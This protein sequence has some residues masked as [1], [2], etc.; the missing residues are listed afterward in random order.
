[1][2]QAR[3][4]L[5]LVTVIGVLAA[6]CSGD[7]GE[8]GDD[9]RAVASTATAVAEPLRIVV[10]NDDGVMAPG[11]D[12]LVDTLADLDD[13]EVT[14]V[15]PAD[16]Q[17]GAS[18][19][20]SP[21]TP[22]T[23]E[24]ATAGGYPALAVEGFPSDSV[25]YALDGGVDPPPDL[26]V[27][28]I[29]SSMNV[30]KSRHLSGTVG[31][32][33]TAARGGVAALASSHTEGDPVDYSTAADLTVA[34]VEEN[35]SALLAGDL[36]GTLRSLNVP[37]CMTG[38]VRGVV[39]VPPDDSDAELIVVADCQSSAEDPSSDVEAVNIGFASLSELD[40]EMTGEQFFPS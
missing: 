14:V 34:W 8:S 33:A 11:I 21:E 2:V 25:N 29:N 37:T 20:A 15:A 18:D 39:E 28:G 4:A 1:V 7:D 27:S 22:P 35:H 9:A 31:A 12:E 24:S 38:E 26:V 23:E 13:T 6:A 32:A 36:A 10:T 5:V 40:P 30:G 3:R 17:S 19:N 16:E